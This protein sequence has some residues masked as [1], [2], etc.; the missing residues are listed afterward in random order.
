MNTQLV[1]NAIFSGDVVGTA[2]DKKNYIL[3]LANDCRGWYSPVFTN[4]S[5][6]LPVSNP[7]IVTLVHSAPTDN[8]ALT[9]NDNGSFKDVTELTN[10]P[11]KEKFSDLEKGLIVAGA[12]LIIIKLLS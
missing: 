8:I 10:P 6:Y 4:E 7:S 2:E 12:A 11:H 3:N 5:K 9:L 1:Y